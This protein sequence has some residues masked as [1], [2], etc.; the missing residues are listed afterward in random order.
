MHWIGRR[1]RQDR[2]VKYGFFVPEQAFGA[3]ALGFAASGLTIKLI[4]T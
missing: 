2:T 3:E 1:L 4:S